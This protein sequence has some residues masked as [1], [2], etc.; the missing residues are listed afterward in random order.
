MLIQNIIDYLQ[1]NK[2]LY[3]KEALQAELLKAGYDKQEVDDGL[4]IVY[5]DRPKK[6]SVKL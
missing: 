4:R 2:N 1:Q 3:D 5:G 6:T